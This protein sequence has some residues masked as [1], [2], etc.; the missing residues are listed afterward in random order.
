MKRV[1][2][3]RLVRL[4]A[5]Q[6]GAWMRHLVSYAMV[7]RNKDD[8]LIQVANA[9]YANPIFSIADYADADPDHCLTEAEWKALLESISRSLPGDDVATDDQLPVYPQEQ[10]M[11]EL[12][13]KVLFKLIRSRVDMDRTGYSG[14]PQFFHSELLFTFGGLFRITFEPPP[15]AV[16]MADFSQEGEGEDGPTL[17]G[18][19][20]IDE[21]DGVIEIEIGPW[22]M[23]QTLRHRVFTPFNL[24]FMS[25]A[26]TLSRQ[27]RTPPL[28]RADRVSA[29]TALR[30]SSISSPDNN[31]DPFKIKRGSIGNLVLAFRRLKA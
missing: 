14:V 4:D 7:L 5:S 29:M 20:R 16:P 23:T 27:G 11:A 9:E 6:S 18:N 31:L 15:A 8:L 28:P 10:E 1:P 30:G 17:T 26:E 24:L 21:R 25:F 3:N 2:Q 19:I 22:N 13:D 12:R